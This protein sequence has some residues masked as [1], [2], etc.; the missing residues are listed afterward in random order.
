MRAAADNG[1]VNWATDR[2]IENRPPL[3]RG[4]VLTVAVCAK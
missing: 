1:A 2:R 3:E 4:P